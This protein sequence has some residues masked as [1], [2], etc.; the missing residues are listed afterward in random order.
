MSSVE[1]LMDPQ[2]QGLLQ[3]IIEST[4]NWTSN[5]LENLYGSLERILEKKNENDNMPNIIQNCLLVLEESKRKKLFFDY[6]DD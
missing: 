5:Q 6:E 2:L 4:E 3:R 1:G